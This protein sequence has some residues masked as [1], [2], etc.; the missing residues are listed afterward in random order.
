MGRPS[1]DQGMAYGPDL[2]VE[3][4]GLDVVEVLLVDGGTW[5]PGEGQKLRRSGE[6]IAKAV[7]GGPVADRIERPQRQWYA[8]DVQ[9]C[10]GLAA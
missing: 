1:S 6:L 3:S 5:F 9:L 10:T 7:I 2:V 4:P 8:I